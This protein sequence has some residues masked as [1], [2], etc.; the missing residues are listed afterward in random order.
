MNYKFLITFFALGLS[1]LSAQAQSAFHTEVDTP[2]KPWTHLEFNDRTEDFNFVVVGD[3]AGGTRPGIF[4]DAMEK[5]NLL[6]PEF[7]ICVGDLIRGNTEDQKQLDWER[8]DLDSLVQGLNYPF[9]YVVGNHD[10]SNDFMRK[11]WENRY[12]KRYYHF[13]YKNVLFLV[14]DSTDDEAAG[15]SPAQVDYAKKALKDNPDVRWTFVLFHHP[16][17]TWE[18]N[19]FVEVEAALADRKYTVLAG[20]EHTYNYRIRNNRDYLSLAT[21]GGGSAMRGSAFGEFDHVMSISMRNEEPHYANIATE[22]IFEKDLYTPKSDALSALVAGNARM[23]NVLLCSPG[24][25][26]EK[27]TLNLYFENPTPY[28]AQVDLDFLHH[29]HL[30]LSETQKRITL[31]PN[32]REKVTLLLT[33]GSGLSYDQLE[34]LRWHWKVQTVSSGLKHELVL[35]GIKTIPVSPSA[36]DLVFPKS[37]EFEETETVGFRMLD[38]QLQIWYQLTPNSPKQ[39]YHTPFTLGQDTDLIYW[40]ENEDGQVS[41]TFSKEFRKTE[42]KESV[43]LVQPSPGLRYRYFEGEWEKLQDLG[44]QTPLDSGV[45]DDGYYLSDIKKREDHFVVVMEGYLKVPED[46]FFFIQTKGDDATKL[47]LHG[48]LICSQDP[49]QGTAQVGISLK[50]G[51]HPIRIEYLETTGSERF[52]MYQK[53]KWEDEWEYMEFEDWLFIEQPRPSDSK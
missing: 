41:K 49:S 6:H 26:F 4:E 33:S 3:R 11:D 43:V 27:G 53:Q 36:T 9:F 48:E 21:T 1:I 50:K 10:I 20:H 2:K 47:Y 22:G 24:G 14:L 28:T 7:V 15:L 25:A 37:R 29:N 23:E 45:F 12:G 46:Q 40:M 51:F 32:S 17:W 31:A 34:N 19:R 16:I 35:E 52:R 13:V 39:R 5:I 30:Q 44:W 8:N 38:E 18:N 42:V